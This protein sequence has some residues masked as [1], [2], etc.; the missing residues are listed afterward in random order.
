MHKQMLYKFT[1]CIGQGRV[2][3]NVLAKTFCLLYSMGKWISLQ[4]NEWAGKSGT[5]PA[6]GC[7]HPVS[8]CDDTNSWQNQSGVDKSLFTIPFSVCNVCVKKA[9][10]HKFSEAILSHPLSLL[11]GLSVLWVSERY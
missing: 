3:V 7:Y 5:L 6:D 1:L 2:N 4:P 11:I 8:S 10:V 9:D